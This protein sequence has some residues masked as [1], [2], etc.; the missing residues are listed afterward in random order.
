MRVTDEMVG[1][2]LVWTRN[3]GEVVSYRTGSGRGRRFR[4]RVAPGVTRNGQPFRPKQAILDLLG[5]EPA[6]VVPTELMLTAREALVFAMGCAAGRA[7]A[8]AG[9]SESWAEEWPPEAREAFVA[10]REEA[11]KADR[12][13]SERERAEREAERLRAVAE[14]RRRKGAASRTLEGGE[15]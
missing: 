8:L 4:V 5:H 11:I 13:E 10:W 6:D 2:W 1:R 12:E 7:A 9:H 15:S 3:Y 14:Y